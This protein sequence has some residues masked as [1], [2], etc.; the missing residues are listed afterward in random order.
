GELA[1]LAEGERELVGR[2]AQQRLRL[3]R[4]VVELRQREP[5][6]ERERDEPLL[7][8]V[9]QVPLQPPALGVSRLDEPRARRAQLLE[10]P[11]PLGQVEPAD[12]EPEVAAPVQDRGA[13][14]RAQALAVA[15]EPAELL[16]DA[17]RAARE[18]R[19]HPTRLLAVLRD[20]EDLPERVAAD[21]VAVADPR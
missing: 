14:R 4:L 18:L 7:R 20:D 19:E 1:E 5:E 12:Q 13:R 17:R 9:V 3:A 15:A 21:E 2:A 6:R 16:L 10:V 11:L 8:T